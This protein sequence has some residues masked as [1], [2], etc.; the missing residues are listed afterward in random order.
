MQRPLSLRAAG[1]WPQGGHLASSGQQDR[2]GDRQAHSGKT[3]LLEVMENK[4]SLSFLWDIVHTRE[5]CL[6]QGA[7]WK[8]PRS[9]VQPPCP[10]ALLAAW[11]SASARWEWAASRCHAV[12]TPGLLP[13]PFLGGGWR[14]GA[15]SPASGLRVFLVRLWPLQ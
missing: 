13:Q 9:S 3:F 8:L 7:F 4:G 1:G 2:R 6:E 15:P 12:P 10:T 5:R 14:G 11:P